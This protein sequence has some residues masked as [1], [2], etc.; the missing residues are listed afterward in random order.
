M[1]LIDGSR[2]IGLVVSR[3][4]PFCKHLFVE[5]FTQARVGV[6]PITAENETLLRSGYAARTDKELPILERFFPRHSLSD[7]QIPR[8]LFLDIILYSKEQ[9]L[10]ESAAM[11][12]PLDQGLISLS[13]AATRDGESFD[14][15]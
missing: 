15:V 1:R 12:E 14:L 9:I 11:N 2:L 3:Y 5:N 8:A 13:L 10:K 4:A 6:L 7:D